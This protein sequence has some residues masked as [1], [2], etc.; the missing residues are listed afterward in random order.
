MAVSEPNR[1]L[2]ISLS[3]SR[4]YHAVEMQRALC[5]S[6]VF[7]S[8]PK[9]ERGKERQDMGNIY[10]ENIP[11]ASLVM[12]Y[13]CHRERERDMF[14]SV[15]PYLNQL[16]SLLAVLS[17]SVYERSTMTHFPPGSLRQSFSSL[18]WISGQHPGGDTVVVSTCDSLSGAG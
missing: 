7:I 6:S 11:W 8:A 13:V 1:T 18:C 5:F 2:I 4:C 10:S 9:E 17:Q 12:F 16:M 14:V 15:A 3:F